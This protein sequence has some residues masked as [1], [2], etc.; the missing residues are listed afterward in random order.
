MLMLSSTS[1][2]IAFNHQVV[3]ATGGGEGEEIGL[4]FDYIYNI[5]KDLS[6][7]TFVAPLDHGISKGRAFGTEGERYAKDSNL[8]LSGRRSSIVAATSF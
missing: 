7:I 2:L 6:N 4:D 5:T 3:K 8:T 1:M